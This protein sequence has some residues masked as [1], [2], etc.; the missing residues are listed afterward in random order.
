MIAYQSE[1]H[2]VNSNSFN[3]SQSEPNAVDRSAFN[4]IESIPLDTTA[5]VRAGQGGT[6][7]SDP[8]SLNSCSAKGHS[9]REGMGM[10]A[11][12]PVFPLY[13]TYRF[14]RAGTDFR[15]RARIALMI[16]PN[17]G[18][19]WSDSTW[20][21][22][23]RDTPASRTICVIPRAGRGVRTLQIPSQEEVT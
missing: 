9:F 4:A 18:L 3:A 8:L 5:I 12:L 14:S 13:P 21:R 1:S 16:V 6:N 17:S 22:L 15:S 23:S 10:H 20:Y 2:A 11:G 19:P 7:G